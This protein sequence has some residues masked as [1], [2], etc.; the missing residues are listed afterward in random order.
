VLTHPSRA[1]ALREEMLRGT[2]TIG[3]RQHALTKYA[4][5]RAWT[6]VAV[7]VGT[8]AVKLAHRDG[9]LLQVTPE[10]DSVAALA[11]EHGRSQADVLAEALAAA[12][13]AGLVP[14][15][16]LPESLRAAAVSTGQPGR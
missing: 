1:E 12:R 15:A 13:S 3:V 8:V 6:E 16:A 11:A 9:L 2:T 5:P 10:F 14:G 4:L 7:G